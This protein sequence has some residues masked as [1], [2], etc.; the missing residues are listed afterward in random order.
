MHKIAEVL[1][2]AQSAE[3][4]AGPA[5]SAPSGDDEDVIDA[6]YTEEKG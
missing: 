5:Q 6:E 3:G 4:D 2:K 1:Y